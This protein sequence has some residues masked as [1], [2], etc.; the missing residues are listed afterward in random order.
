LCKWQE[1]LE[2]KLR[3]GRVIIQTYSPDNYC[4]EQAKEQNYESFFETEIAIRKQL[5]YPPFCDIILFN[6]NSIDET[7]IEKAGQKIYR[8]LE[9][10]SKK[11]KSNVVIF[12]P[13]QSPI[14]KIKNKY[15]WRIIVK[16]RLNNNVIDLV[17]NTLE[18]FYKLK[19]KKTTVIVDVNPNSMM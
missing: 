10:N 15:R 8:I 3:S 16:C 11:L 13:V 14:N 17:N 6:I 19:Y 7:E 5:N 2:E 4:I 12:K 1:E 9:N 18:D